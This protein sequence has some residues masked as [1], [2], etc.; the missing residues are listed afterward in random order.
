MTVFLPPSPQ[1]HCPV[2]P[3]RVVELAWEA[4]VSQHYQEDKQRIDLFSCTWCWFGDI[5]FIT[6][7]GCLFSLSGC[8]ALCSLMPNVPWFPP[9]LIV[10]ISSG[11]ST[12]C[13]SS[14]V[15]LS[16]AMSPPNTV[17]QCQRDLIHQ[18]HLL[19]TCEGESLYLVD[20]ETSSH[21]KSWL[22]SQAVK[23]R[24]TESW[25]KYMLFPKNT[26]QNPTPGKVKHLSA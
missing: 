7:L 26:K 3:S 6:H 9:V 5:L 23:E 12:C 25:G 22:G 11:F 8:S 24:K 10:L 1:S 18:R 16:V 14:P 19:R 2:F 13:F 20:L 21:H 17:G 4:V 15:A